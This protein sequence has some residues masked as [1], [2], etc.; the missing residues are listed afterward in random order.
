MKDRVGQVWQLKSTGTVIVIV[1]SP[2]TADATG[3][4]FVYL[5]VVGDIYLR[6]FIAESQLSGPSQAWQRVT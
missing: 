6:R 1:E 4:S 2:R 3:H 5:N